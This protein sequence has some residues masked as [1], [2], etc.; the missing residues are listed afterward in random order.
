MEIISEYDLE[1]RKDSKSSLSEPW[2][3]ISSDSD[4]YK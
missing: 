3:L 1:K 2:R 4:F